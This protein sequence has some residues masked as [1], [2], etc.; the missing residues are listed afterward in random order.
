M[1]GFSTYEPKNKGYGPQI[2]DPRIEEARRTLGGAVQQ[3]PTTRLR[4]Y[5]EDLEM[6]QAQADSGFLA[7]ACQLYRSMQRDG[8]LAGLLSRRT[9]GVLALPRRFYGSMPNVIEDLQSLNGS[10]SVFDEMCPPSELKAFVADGDTIGLA[11]G[12]LVPVDGRDYPVLVRLDPEFLQYIWVE[13]RWYYISRLGRFPITPGDGRW[14]LHIPGGRIAPWRW[15]LW[16]A[17][18]RAFIQKEHAIST[19]AGF[20]ASIANPARVIE[21]PLGASEKERRAFFSHVLNWGPNTVLEVPAGWSAKVLEV[22]G[23]AWEVFQKQIDMC[24][25]EYMVALEG[26]IVTTTGGAG[27]Q[28]SEVPERATQKL[29]QTSA[30]ALAYTLNTQVIPQFVVNR[31]GFDAIDAGTSV[32]WNAKESFEQESDSRTLTAVAAAI[33]ALTE[34][35]APYKEQLDILELTTRFGIP[36]AGKDSAGQ[37]SGSVAPKRMLELAPPEEQDQAAE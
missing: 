22:V 37:P 24:D 9:S 1:L 32:A 2:D 12:E 28:N 4:W 20:I 14:V 26:Q 36:L 15:G 13:S 34:A 3:Q 16:P 8:Q 25:H 7:M 29:I 17:L 10:R 11:V 33:K 23:R 31:Y 35:L 5:L 6:A 18:G 30:D 27:F 21:A 19:R